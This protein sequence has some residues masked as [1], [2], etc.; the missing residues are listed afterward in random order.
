M[1]QMYDIYL[2][3][4]KGKLLTQTLG[5]KIDPKGSVYTSRL[6]SPGAS[7]GDSHAH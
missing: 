5:T 3:P 7:I 4:S 6:H 1:L 2:L